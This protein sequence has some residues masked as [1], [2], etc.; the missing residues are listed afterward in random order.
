MYEVE[1]APVGLMYNGLRLHQITSQFAQ[2]TAL[3]FHQVDM[4]E[5]ILVPHAVNH[6]DQS[7]GLAVQVGLVNLLD[8]AGEHHLGTFSGTGDDGFD[9]MRGQ[10]LGFVNDA[11]GFAQASSADEGQGLDD[12]LSAL[13]HVVQ[14]FQ[15]GGGGREL[16]LDDVQV[17]EEGLHVGGYF[18][19]CV[20]GQEADVF[21][22]QGY[23]GACQQDL[24]VV[25]HLPQGSGQG[26]QGLSGA[27]LACQGHQLDVG[28]VQY[29]EGETLFGISRLD[30][31]VPVLVHPFHHVAERIVTGQYTVTVAFQDETFVGVYDLFKVELV[32]VDAFPR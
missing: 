11:V 4:R 19:L 25:A 27:G 1:Y 13:L 21:V 32:D 30:A 31:V 7:V 14:P 16:M 24:F 10:V 6:I 26:Q 28:V 15:F 29:F 12:Q 17:V 2:F 22:G 20:A 8:I 5:E 3:A 23:D 9:F 18:F